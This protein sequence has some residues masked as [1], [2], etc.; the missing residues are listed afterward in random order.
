MMFLAPAVIV[1]VGVAGKHPEQVQRQ[2]APVLAHAHVAPRTVAKAELASLARHSDDSK[3]IVQS[4]H[5]DGVVGGALIESGGS[6]TLRVVIYDGDGNLKSLGETPLGGAKMS[7]DELDVLGEN[8]DDE[9]GGIHHKNGVAPEAKQE[10]ADIDFDTPAPK[11]AAAPPPPPPKRKAAPA[12]EIGFAPDADNR[13]APSLGGGDA[14]PAE[15][16]DAKP[17]ETADAVSL[18]DVAS[19]NS[20]TEDTGDSA[21]T[22][23]A[24]AEHALHLHANG[25][26]GV[27]SRSFSGPSGLMGYTSSAVGTAR[28]AAGIEPVGH[29]SLDAMAETALGMSTPIGNSTAST[30]MS[31]YEITASYAF[32]SSAISIA[33]TFGYG[34]RAFSIDSSA[35]GRSP[36]T[37]YGY[38]IL[39]AN[40][41][42]ALSQRFTLRALA[43]LE[44]V[45]GG[46]DPTAMEFGAAT[47]WALDAGA[48]LDVRLWSHVLARAAFDYQRFS[49]SW[50]AA[51][52]RSTNGATDSYPT[53]AISIGA[54]Y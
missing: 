20:A 42:Y 45:T 13:D 3:T 33:P 37:S 41:A 22:A 9:L 44:P 19:L 6:L 27:A 38:L 36:D 8:L 39:G 15:S 2:L 31:R 10:V 23:S 29:L 51:G 28:V 48:G 53:A 21:A 43:A 1:F 17:T 16:H 49:W 40:A 25:G 50:S 34:E 11:A 14:K 4:L 26:F 24:P 32:G 52:S 7:K 30:S 18:D 12:A 35:T 46:E 5:V 54:E 47:R